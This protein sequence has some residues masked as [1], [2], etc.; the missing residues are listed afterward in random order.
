MLA[1]LLLGR[2]EAGGPDGPGDP[3]P[4]VGLPAA[5]IMVHGR[6]QGCA[7]DPGEEGRV[8][9]VQVVQP[10]RHH[11]E[12]PAPPFCLVQQPLR[13]GWSPVSEG[14]SGQAQPTGN[15]NRGLGLRTQ[16]DWHRGR[17]RASLGFWEPAG[18]QAPRKQG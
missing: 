5:F 18:S 2:A 14:Q 16:A 11:Q 7:M 12:A 9:G 6:L 4:L 13:A 15:R 17:A 1:H 3:T 8:R 10:R